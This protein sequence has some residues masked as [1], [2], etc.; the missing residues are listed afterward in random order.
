MGRVMCSRDGLHKPGPHLGLLRALLLQALQIEW[1]PTLL[2]AGAAR[3]QVT[4]DGVCSPV[5]DSPLGVPSLSEPHAYI[6]A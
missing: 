2:T 3:A 6:P 5:A 1:L 4:A